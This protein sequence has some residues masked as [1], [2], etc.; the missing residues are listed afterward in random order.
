MAQPE[1]RVM[2][3]LAVF[4]GRVRMLN[5]HCDVRG[6]VTSSLGG[7]RA[8]VTAPRDSWLEHAAAGAHTD[9]PAVLPKC[10][11]RLATGVLSRRAGRG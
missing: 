4:S 8:A 1:P 2:V 9:V 5:S 11:A 3:F 6:P 7:V 10:P